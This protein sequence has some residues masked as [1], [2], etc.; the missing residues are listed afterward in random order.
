MSDNHYYGCCACI[1]AA[2]IGLVPKMALLTTQNGF[3]LNLFVNG[4]METVT[5]GGSRITFKTETDYPVNGKIVITL[6]M[7]QSE[8]FELLIRIPSWSKQT[9][10]AVNGEA[11]DVQHGYVHLSRTWTCGD[12]IELTLD[13]RTEA[14]Y[15]IPYGQQIL[16]NKVIWG[17]NYMIPT[18]DE[19]DPIAKNHV[20]LRR[21]PVILAQENRLGYSVDDPVSICVG[22]DGYVDV[23]FAEQE[24]AP[25]EHILEME[26]PLTDG[27]RMH[28]TDYASAGKLWTEESKMAAWMLTEE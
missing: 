24:I 18:Y 12:T 7:E 26:V 25:Y 6:D 3:A 9:G 10:L 19:E 5:A 23:C 20:A 28:V 1:G 21:G 11:R 17:A 16:M 4:S 13:M 15:P 14:L 2:G 22:E 8:A 27:S